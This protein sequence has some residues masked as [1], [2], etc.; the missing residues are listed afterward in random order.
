MGL[1][2][3][4]DN[5]FAERIALVFTEPRLRD[6]AHRFYEEVPFEFISKITSLQALACAIIFGVTLTPAAVIFPVLI[7]I[8][9]PLRLLLLPQFMEAKF[10]KSVD[11]YEGDADA[12]GEYDDNTPEEMGSA[13]MTKK[14][15]S[16]PKKKKD[17]EAAASSEDVIV[18][19]RDENG[20]S[21]AA[22]GGA[23]V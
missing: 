16:A 14:A 23:H 17:Y 13:E 4:A 1:A 22:D 2:S 8:L 12:P 20:H 10:V 19:K 9:I 18:V 11:P 3:F 15:A 6:C 21:D 7:G 5:Q